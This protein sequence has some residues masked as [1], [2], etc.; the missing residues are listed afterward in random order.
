LTVWEGI[1]LTVAI[2][3][4]FIWERGGIVSTIRWLKRQGD[5]DK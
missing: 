1:G 5:K 2:F 4:A 3:I